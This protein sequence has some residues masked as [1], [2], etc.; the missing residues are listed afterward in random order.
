MSS[1]PNEDF[2]KKVSLFLDNELN[3]EARENFLTEVRGNPDYTAILKK[4]KEF[5]SFLKN[6]IARRAMSP[7][8]VQRIKDRIRVNPL[9]R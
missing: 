2:A 5:K 1:Q 9:F 8:V 4:E 6:N 7:D 3:H